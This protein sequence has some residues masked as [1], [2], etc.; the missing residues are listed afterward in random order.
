[1]RVA[2]RC[3][4]ILLQQGLKGEVGI[5]GEQGIPGPPVCCAFNSLI[6]LTKFQSVQI[7]FSV[8]LS[9]KKLKLFSSDFSPIQSKGPMGLRGYP[10]M[11]G[12]KGEAVSKAPWMFFIFL[13]SLL[14]CTFLS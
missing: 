14:W 13:L 1:M 10:G 2:N 4:F 7:V 8:R 12:P 9:R 6:F 5:S 11:M 3:F